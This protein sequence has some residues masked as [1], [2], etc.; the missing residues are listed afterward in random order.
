[1]NNTHCRS[2]AG[3]V[4]IGDEQRC[5]FHSDA[6]GQLLLSGGHSSTVFTVACE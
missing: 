6:D 5:I 1:M 4:H 3:D 2:W